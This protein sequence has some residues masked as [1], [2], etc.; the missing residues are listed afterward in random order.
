MVNYSNCQEALN[1]SFEHAKRFVK[2]GIVN[3]VGG[4]W[5]GVGIG[6]T[7]MHT[8]SHARPTAFS[9]SSYIGTPCQG[10]KNSSLLAAVCSEIRLGVHG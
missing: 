7:H 10:G 2:A 5:N 1:C 4:D 9:S 8:T 3:A 6:P